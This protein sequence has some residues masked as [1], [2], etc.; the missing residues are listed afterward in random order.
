MFR[1]ISSTL[2]TGNS[3]F[4]NIIQN[5]ILYPTSIPFSS[6]DITWCSLSTNDV[7]TSLHKNI[8]PPVITSLSFSTPISDFCESYRGETP[9]TYSKKKQIIPFYTDISY[10]TP[11]AD[12]IG[13]YPNESIKIMKGK[14]IIEALAPSTDARIITTADNN[15]EIQHVNEAWTRL[16]GY[17]NEECY[18]KTLNIIQGQDTDKKITKELVYLLQKN[19]S[20]QAI[21]VNYDKWG[22][23]FNNHLSVEPIISNYTGNVTHYL[24]V[25]K[26]IE[27]NNSK[28]MILS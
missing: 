18:G 4:K 5:T 13:K 27:H 6:P 12:F 26:D 1:T 2:L 9:L 25:L 15:F 21:I 3:K 14:T 22:R 10:S 17:S 24:G 7:K 19:N 20:A 28:Q 8:I 23:R 16:C 11:L